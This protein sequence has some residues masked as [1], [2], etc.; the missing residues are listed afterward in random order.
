MPKR[1]PNTARHATS[2]GWPRTGASTAVVI[3]Q[4]TAPAPIQMASVPGAPTRPTAASAMP[5]TMAIEPEH[6]PAAHPLLL[7]D[8]VVA[9]RGDR[10]HLRG[11]AGRD[12]GRDHRDDD[13]DDVA[14]DDR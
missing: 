3:T 9:H 2:T 4:M 5:T 8:Q 12:E 10:R 7:H 6:E 11:A 13:A 1:R 14:G